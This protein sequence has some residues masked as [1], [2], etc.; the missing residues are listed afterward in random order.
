MSDLDTISRADLVRAAKLAIR[1]AREDGV[2]VPTATVRALMRVARTC[3]RIAVGC[4]WWVP[5]AD[6][7][8]LV[9]TLHARE[10]R[11][12]NTS[13]NCF[14]SDEEYCVGVNFPF[15]VAQVTGDHQHTTRRDNAVVSVVDP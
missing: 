9:G 11:E 7:G 2:V 12:A 15:A 8:C 1:L 10:A 4:E 3:D 13:P 6:C 14:L 5:A